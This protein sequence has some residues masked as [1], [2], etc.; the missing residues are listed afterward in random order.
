MSDQVI[1]A[2]LNVQGL[3]DRSKRKMW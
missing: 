1:I 3:C 2:S